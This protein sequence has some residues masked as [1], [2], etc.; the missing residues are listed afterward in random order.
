MNGRTGLFL[1]WV[2]TLAM[3]MAELIQNTIGIELE[4]SQKYG[5]LSYDSA[6]SHGLPIMVIG[7][8]VALLFAAFII[9]KKRKWKWV[10]IGVILMGIGSA[11]PIPLESDAVTNGFELILLISLWS[12][13][14]FLEKNS[15]QATN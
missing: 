11:V 1:T 3:I 5:V 8:T 13:K 4:P 14:V 6:G 10:A 12:T 9:W 7:V 15:D 2:Y